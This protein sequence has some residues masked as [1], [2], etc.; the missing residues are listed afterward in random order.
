VHNKINNDD[1][2]NN[3]YN[4]NHNSNIVF[5]SKVYH[6][7]TRHTGTLFCSGDLDF[8]PMT[9]M[10]K[11]DLKVVKMYLQTRNELCRSRLLTGKR[12]KYKIQQLF[13]L[14]PPQSD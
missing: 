13:L 7:Q 1:N 2:N 12:I 6:P 5:Q 4:H 14:H 11:L 3:I 10:Y 8:D 9:L